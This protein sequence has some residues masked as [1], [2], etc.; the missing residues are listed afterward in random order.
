MA[1]Q[2]TRLTSVEISLETTV[3]YAIKQIAEG[4]AMLQGSM[5]RGFDE[6]KKH[7]DDRLVPLEETVRQHSATLRTLSAGR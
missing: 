7:I 1:W 6:V 5:D 3:P 4:H 2:E